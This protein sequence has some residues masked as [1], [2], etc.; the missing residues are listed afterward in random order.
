M[1]IYILNDKLERIKPI[2]IYTSLTWNTYYQNIGN[3]TLNVPLYLFEYLVPSEESDVFIEYTRDKRNIGV[4]ESINKSTD[5]D[6]QKSLI[7]K[8]RMGTS[9]LNR[10]VSMGDNN[11]EDKYPREIVKTMLE[12]N[13]L[14]PSDI[15]RKIDLISYSEAKQPQL[16]KTDYEQKRGDEV[17]SSIEE[18]S[19]ASNFGFYMG[20]S[21]DATQLEFNIYQGVDRSLNQSEVAPF[22]V[23]QRRGISTV[24]D[25][26][27]DSTDYKNYAEVDKEDQVRTYYPKTN[28]KSGLQR[29]ETFFDMSAVSQTITQSDGTEIVIADNYYENMIINDTISRLQDLLPT[30]YVDAEL[31]K[32]VVAKFRESLYLGDII[33]LKDDE[34][35]LIMNT[36]ISGATEVESKS[37]YEI[38]LQLGDNNI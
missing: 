32:Q 1:K 17:I 36:I 25:Y 16:L 4:V 34:S 13:F 24:M 3:F 20:L 11:F 14:S 7:V 19:K 5:D 23:Q 30:E 9:L 27:K 33:T 18:L 2:S 10:R 31:N 28:Q 22:V 6:G 29:R 8:G 37:G 38:S 35:G 12:A 26:Y 15:L 21:E